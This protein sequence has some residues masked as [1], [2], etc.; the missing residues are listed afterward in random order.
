LFAIIISSLFSCKRT[1]FFAN[2]QT[3]LQLCKEIDVKKVLFQKISGYFSCFCYKKWFFFTL[4]EK[5]KPQKPSAAVCD[6]RPS[7][8]PHVYAFERTLSRKP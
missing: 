7:C 6:L 4:V 2:L 5:Q 3:I 1:I 8:C